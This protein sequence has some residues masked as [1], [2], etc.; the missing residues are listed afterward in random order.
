MVYLACEAIAGTAY[1][2][3]D[4]EVAEVAWRDHLTMTSHVPY[5][6]FG[7]VQEYLDATFGHLTTP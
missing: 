7:P 4:D 2:A 5:P 6:L 1:A 3:A